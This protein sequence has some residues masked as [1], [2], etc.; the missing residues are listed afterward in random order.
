MTLKNFL[1]KSL[2]LFTSVAS[3]AIIAGYYSQY[4]DETLKKNYVKIQKENEIL[5]NQIN[6]L[7]MDELKNELAKSKVETLKSSLEICNNKISNEVEQ[8]NKL[9]ANN[10]ELLEPHLKNINKEDDNINST[11]N[12]II[13]IFNAISNKF[14]GDSNLIE[15]FKLF[16][17]K[18]NDFISSL[19]LEQ[20]GLVAHITTSIFIIVC[21]FN[22]LSVLMS[23]FLIKYFEL[24]IKFPKLS[25]FLQ[26]R[27]KFQTYY[28][29]LNFLLIFI[30]LITLIY[31]DFRVLL[32]IL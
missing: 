6:E 14:F 29:I 5:R 22:I 19:N 13:E 28:L 32:L 1:S 31:I 11:I 2:S 27:R 12:E 10:Y 9:E 26:L 8:I 21:L 24:E 17:N 23:D 30:T 15:K 4:T 20:V 25:I 3:A 18:W 16:I 7:K